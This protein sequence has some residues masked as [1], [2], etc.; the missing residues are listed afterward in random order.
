MNEE[1]KWNKQKH[2]DRVQVIGPISKI[3]VSGKYPP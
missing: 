1:A 2:G 3:I